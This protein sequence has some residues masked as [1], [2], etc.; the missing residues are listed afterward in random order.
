[1][2][3]RSNLDDLEDKNSS[4][5]PMK[6]LEIETAD[7]K[8]KLGKVTATPAKVPQEKTVQTA[9]TPHQQAASAMV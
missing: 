4:M 5:S 3:L 2:L 9:R 8:L 1:M 6:A 7:T